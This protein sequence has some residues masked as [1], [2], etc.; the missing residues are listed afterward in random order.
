[1]FFSTATRPTYRKI[2]GLDLQAIALACGLK[3]SRSTPRDHST[4]FSESVGL[5]VLLDA[6]PVGTIT[7]FDGP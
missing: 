5:Q 4:T 3:M 7:A 6:R 2:G 1:M